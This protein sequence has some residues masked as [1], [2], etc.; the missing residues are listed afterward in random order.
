MQ[1]SPKVTLFGVIL[2]IVILSLT[3]VS[4]QIQVLPNERGGNGEKIVKIDQNIILLANQKE[5]HAISTNGDL[6]WVW[7]DEGTIYDVKFLNDW[8]SDGYKEILVI[9]ES[10]IMP[11]TK[12][13]DGK[14]GSVKKVL[15]FTAKTYKNTWPTYS[16]KI[17]TKDN[18]I[19]LSNF[20]RIYEISNNAN[21]IEEKLVLPK[22]VQGMSF[23][24]NKLIIVDSEGLTS[25]NT[26]FRKD[27][28]LDL[29]EEEDFYGRQNY[30]KSILI[31]DENILSLE[32][33]SAKIYNSR[34][35]RVHQF[36]IEI[37]ECYNP[38][39]IFLFRD[40]LAVFENSGKLT[41]YDFSGTKLIE[42]SNVK[43]V[44]RN[45]NNL[46]YVSDS[47]DAFELNTLTNG[48]VNLY[49]GPHFNTQ[50]IT[51][52][53]KDYS[54][55]DSG[56]TLSLYKKDSLIGSYELET[57]KKVSKIDG[58]DFI[59][60]TGWPFKYVYRGRTGEITINDAK[61]KNIL[62]IKEVS[63]LDSDGFPEILLGF[64]TSIDHDAV[65]LF[66]I[67]NTATNSNNLVS[68]I[69]N[70]D[71]LADIIDDLES[72]IDDIDDE[73]QDKED[74]VSSKYNEISVLNQELAVLNSI[75]DPNNQTLQAQIASLDNQVENLEEDISELNDEIPTLSD[76]RRNLER[77][78]NSYQNEGLDITNSIR[79]YVVFK[80]K[81][82][83][84]VNLNSGNKY[85]IDLFSH[86]KEI[87]TALEGSYS[88]FIEIGDINNNGHDDVMFI[89]YEKLGAFDT[90]N[91]NI[92]WEK[93]T[94][95]YLGTEFW[96]HDSDAQ[97]IEGADYIVIPYN[98]ESNDQNFLMKIDV[99]N[100]DS[101]NIISGGRINFFSES[102]GS[103]IYEIDQV[104]HLFMDN[105]QSLSLT[106]YD[107][108]L[109]TPIQSD[110]G[111]SIVSFYDCD[112]NG[113]KDAVF[114]TS[115]REKSVLTCLDT[116]TL[117]KIR[118][119]IIS[120][121]SDA[122]SR[123][124]RGDF[125]GGKMVSIY[126][127]GGMLTFLPTKVINDYLIIKEESSSSD[128]GFPSGF[129]VLDLNKEK[130]ISIFLDNVYQSGGII[131]GDGEAVTIVD[132]NIITS[133]SEG[134]RM[135]GDF[136][137]TLTSLDSIAIIRVDNQFY[138]A[139]DNNK[140]LMKLKN[141]NHFIEVSIFDVDQEK[142]LIDSM[143]ITVRRSKSWLPYL[144][145]LITIAI[146]VSGTLKW[147]KIRR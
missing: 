113:R 38:P 111:L 55:V 136:K 35:D 66:I 42:M 57:S 9:S 145:I 90:K 54:L 45:G 5:L 137:I 89:S 92:I 34:L 74:L 52:I 41:S 24:G 80:N 2:L 87:L 27:S 14:G 78:L 65:E 56:N 131:N 40:E 64:S 121:S 97:H 123:P 122:G 30:P 39:E 132:E 68:F 128:S 61:G 84:L 72:D 71:E 101:L 139:T 103:L 130:I 11:S 144:A 43:D 44:A 7:K 91:Y 73:I 49:N 79:D 104:P 112:K 25:Y 75:N 33:G 99:R 119:I 4:A 10:F 129:K 141:G 29:S 81:E 70:E 3:S 107:A 94:D 12:I 31:G 138:T 116:N 23:L 63:D 83:L 17:L 142:Y 146:M 135:D 108:Y 100:G 134:S 16:S 133:P 58:Q 109:P 46:Y 117:Q 21:T 32:C 93:D 48:V 115:S 98:V 6:L 8:D 36:N 95:S 77:Q 47:R 18:N 143:N 118:E 15:P 88:D 114:F 53:D 60:S 69:P 147:R 26:N 76:E 20:K 126:G 96:F 140:E 67:L 62:D 1:N 86:N 50:G 120:Q 106:G 102:K 124:T 110:T 59:I 28:F 127:G 85:I 51:I 125:S 82:K 13:L 105:G 19:I 22:F 37:S